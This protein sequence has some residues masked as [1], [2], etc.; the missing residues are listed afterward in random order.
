MPMDDVIKTAKELVANQ[1][2]EIVLSGIHTGRYGHDLGTDL[3]ALLRRLLNEVEGLQRIRL[4]SIEINELSDEFLTLMQQDERIARHLHIPI[5]SASN[6]VLKA[7]NR[8]YTIE[9][10]IKR[11]NEIR[12]LLPGILIL[13]ILLLAFLMNQK[14]ILMRRCQI[15]IAFSSALCMYFHFLNAMVQGR[16]ACRIKSAV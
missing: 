4:S 16:Q 3:T 15:L 1:H 11:I 12:A 9:A 13:P 7:M 6:H 5:Q 14:K 2:Y 10:F 8:P